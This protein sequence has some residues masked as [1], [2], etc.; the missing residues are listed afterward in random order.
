VTLHSTERSLGAP[1]VRYLRD[2]ERQ[3]DHDELVVLIPEVQP[4][5]RWQRIL[6]NQRGFVLEQ[7]IA[8]GTE[9][10]VV[11]RLRYR[12]PMVQA[13]ASED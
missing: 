13:P 11:C 4:A 3:E 8:H 6:H 9:N 10:V 1:V 12:L 7:A 2:L 5:H